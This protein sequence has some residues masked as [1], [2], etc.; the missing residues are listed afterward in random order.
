[1]G[2]RLLPETPQP[3]AMGSVEKAGRIGLQGVSG[4]AAALPGFAGNTMKAINDWVAAPISKA[5]T[6]SSVPYEETTI[7]KV[8]PTT[9]QH[10]KNLEEGIP[11]LKPRNKIEKFSRDLSSD[12]AELFL[13]GK[14]FKMGGYAFSPVR[15][16]AISL[17]ANL[18][19]EGTTQ[20]TGDEKKGQMVK[21]G[22]MMFLSLFNPT[23]AKNVVSN[24]YNKAEAA[25]P[26]QAT[27]SAASLLTRLSELENKI[28]KGR[29]PQVV[30]G[31]EKFV[32]DEI[33]KVRSLVQGGRINIPALRAQKRSFNEEL[34]KSLFNIAN[35]GEKARAR[36]LAQGIGHAMKDTMKQYGTQNPKWWKL[37][38]S[39]DTAASAMYK[40]NYVSRVL[41]KFMKGRP[42]DMAHAFGI[43]V[44]A[45][46]AYFSP[47]G[48]LVTTL[49][50]Q[51]AKLGT[52][53]AKSKD[54]AKHYAKVTAAALS[55]NPKL[56]NKELDEFQSKI[57][58]E[59]KK[60]KNKYKL[61]PQK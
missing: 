27:H 10:K 7:G 35:R 34:G 25:L 38:Q 32:L 30:A 47:A 9:E 42:E 5:L 51:T 31:S 45:A 11:Y 28:L 55:E 36:E 4:A 20:F 26:Q 13:P 15:S 19:G 50:Y 57:E 8:L 16:L 59:E 41:E 53:I 14:A 49:G 29:S 58:K 52:R 12:A 22:T 24:L 60:R 39:A 44:P 43:A 6:G 1:M 2:F 54:L 40:S 23:S 61:L 21:S 3:A 17:A 46:G 33:N 37:Q 18:A 48:A 56:I